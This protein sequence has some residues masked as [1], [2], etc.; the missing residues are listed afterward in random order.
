MP[1]TIVKRYYPRLSEVVTVQDLPEFLNFLENGL[2]QVFDRIHY[3]NLQYSKSFNGDAAFY[4]LDLVTRDRL[5]FPLTGGMQLVM[6]PDVDGDAGICKSFP[7]SGILLF[8]RRFL[9]TG[10]EGISPHR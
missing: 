9:S 10:F 5:Q 4:S 3:K 1:N 6:N 8:I 2:E 7:P